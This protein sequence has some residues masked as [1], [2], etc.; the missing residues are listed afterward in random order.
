MKRWIDIKHES[1]KNTRN[2]K[3][4]IKVKQFVRIKNDNEIIKTYNK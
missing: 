2:I 4:T 1:F 3:E